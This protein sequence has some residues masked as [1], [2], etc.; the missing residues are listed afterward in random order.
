MKQIVSLLFL[1]A[2]LA[3]CS[4]VEPIQPK[5]LREPVQ[6][7]YD[8]NDTEEIIRLAD[9]ALWASIYAS[10]HKEIIDVKVIRGIYQECNDG[11]FCIDDPTHCLIIV[12][13]EASIKS[14]PIEEALIIKVKPAFP[15]I[16]SAKNID[17]DEGIIQTC[18]G[19]FNGTKATF[20]I[21]N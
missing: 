2:V 4:K 3:G 19:N 16:V 13:G 1:I 7:N 6:Y 21:R 8:A 17:I 14:T 10:S 12:T 5:E 9:E 20:E 11:S 18:Q 15:E